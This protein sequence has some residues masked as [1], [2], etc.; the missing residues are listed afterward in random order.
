MRRFALTITLLG[1]TCLFLVTIPAAAASRGDLCSAPTLKTEKW[2]STTEVGGMTLMLPPGFVAR[3]MATGTKNA[4]TH[5]Y[6]SGTHRFIMIGSGSGPSNLTVR[7]AELT[8]TAECETVLGG[9]RAEL[10]SYMWTAEDDRMS[11]SGEAG[12]QYM[13]VARFFATGATREVYIAFKSNIQSDIG[14][15]RQLFWTVA[16]PG[17]AGGATAPASQTVSASLAAAAPGAV[18]AAPAPAAPACVPTA[19]PTLPAA[20]AVVD[21]A[22]VQMLV[23]GSGPMSNGYALMALKFD[24]SSLAGINVAQSDLP[25]PAQ[26]QLATLVASNLK[27]HDAKSPS[28]FVLRID[29]QD[30]G[31]RYTVQGACAQ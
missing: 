27:P 1:S 31:L 12:P 19:D 7:G 29:T 20:S 30:Q 4:D 25:D 9:R 3:G 10:T 8:Q 18:A 15:N 24:G 14:S 23:S 28:S 22:L 5:G 2:H 16:F 6:F 21:S 13:V 11:P 26:K 17:F